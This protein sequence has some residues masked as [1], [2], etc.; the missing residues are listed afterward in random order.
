MD[1]NP[2]L[3][4]SVSVSALGGALSFPVNLRFVKNLFWVL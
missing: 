3:D 2:W 4:L 1:E